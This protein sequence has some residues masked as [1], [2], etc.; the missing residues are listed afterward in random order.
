MAR[1]GARHLPRPPDD[2]AGDAALDALV[3]LLRREAPAP[4]AARDLLAEPG[5]WFVARAPG[6]LDLMGGIADYSGSLVLQW[7]LSVATLAAVRRRRDGRFRVLSLGSP[8]LPDTR[9]VDLTRAEICPEGELLSPRRMRALLEGER[10]FAAYVLGCFSVLQEVHAL[11]L[12]GGADVLVTSE[13]PEGAGVSS[14]AALEVSVMSALAGALECE[15]PARE[16]ALLCQRVENEAVGA[17][18]GVMDQM[19]S[20]CGEENRLL[21]LLCQPA[22]LQPSIPWPTEL[23]LWGIDSG[24]RHSVAGTGYTEVRIGAFLGYR[25]LAEAAGLACRPIGEGRVA[26][27]GIDE[28]TEIV[29][30]GAYFLKAAL[31]VVPE[32]TDGGGA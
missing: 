30:G 20:C 22:E 14:S 5:C 15:V 3:R 28:G 21:A 12:A 6:R 25:I 1:P 9:R 18:C 27:T 24:V 2:P 23:A 16:R 8:G 7:P 29:V 10:H 13:V 4:G 32:E 17:A 31:D 26:V 19:T 11:E